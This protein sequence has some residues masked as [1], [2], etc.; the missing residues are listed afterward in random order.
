MLLCSPFR[1]LGHDKIPDAIRPDLTVISEFGE[2][3]RQF[4]KEIVQ[5]IG[6]VLG[7]KCLP[8]DI[9]LHIRLEDLG[10][11]C[12]IENKFMDYKTIEVYSEKGDSTISFH[13][14][15]NDHATFNTALDKKKRTR[16]IPL[17]ER[18]T[19]LK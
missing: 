1:T 18:I 19:D 3:L 4:R 14:K 8:G 7:L 5:G 11:Y 10:V 16:A 13:R 9:G 15:E 17:S 6:E 2:E 12:F